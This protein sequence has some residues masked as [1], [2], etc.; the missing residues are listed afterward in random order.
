MPARMR[1]TITL[2]SVAISLPL[3]AISAALAQMG[4]HDEASQHHAPS[5]CCAVPRR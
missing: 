2:I 1:A 5:R 3:L 4:H